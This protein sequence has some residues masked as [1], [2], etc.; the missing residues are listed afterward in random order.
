MWH[1]ETRL[2]GDFGSAGLLAGLDEVEGLCQTK[3]FY[4]M[5]SNSEYTTYL[6]IVLQSL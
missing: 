4:E 1:L 2:I 5:S 6:L 3:W